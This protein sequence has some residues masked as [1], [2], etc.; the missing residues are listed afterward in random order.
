MKQAANETSSMGKLGIW[1][2]RHP[3]GIQFF[4]SADDENADLMDQFI[5][6]MA[7]LDI[8]VSVDQGDLIS[9]LY[10]VWLEIP[11]RL[12]FLTVA[13]YARDAETARSLRNI[14]NAAFR[15]HG[16]WLSG[17]G[18]SAERIAAFERRLA[19]GSPLLKVMAYLTQ[20]ASLHF[21][22]ELES[23]RTVEVERL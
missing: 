9:E 21:Y 18:Y 20:Q 15:D 2:D 16:S 22:D 10:Q 11:S 8:N 23:L 13:K 3:V 14:M 7:E 19:A 12:A 5:L 4:E 1:F 17:K 6:E